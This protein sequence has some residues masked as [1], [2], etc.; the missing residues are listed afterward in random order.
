M[1]WKII[2]ETTGFTFEKGESEMQL[3]KGKRGQRSVVSGRVRLRTAR[4]VGTGF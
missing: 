3:R 4:G 1:A 2:V